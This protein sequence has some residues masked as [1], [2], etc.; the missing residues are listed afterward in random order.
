[1][2]EFGQENTKLSLCKRPKRW[3]GFTLTEVAIVLGVIGLILGGLWIAINNVREN[4]KVSLGVTEIATIVHNIRE[5]YAERSGFTLPNDSE[6]SATLMNSGVFPAEMINAA[7]AH[8]ISN[9]WGGYTLLWINHGGVPNS[10]WISMYNLTKL[11]CADIASAVGASGSVSGLIA[12][13]SWYSSVDA[14]GNTIPYSV[15]TPPIMIASGQ[16]LDPAVAATTCSGGPDGTVSAE[17]V[18]N[19]Q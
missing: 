1:M 18:Y 7:A 16:S 2:S 11:G 14:H 5:L 19:F 12:F 8:P 10:F 3:R 13:E 17:F 15:D 9:P 6:V 4:R